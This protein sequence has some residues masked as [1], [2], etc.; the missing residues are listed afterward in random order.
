MVQDRI[1]YSTFVYSRNCRLFENLYNSQGFRFMKSGSRNPF[2]CVRKADCQILL[3]R[4]TVP[5][6]CCVQYLN[7]SLALDR[8]KLGILRFLYSAGPVNGTWYT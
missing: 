5:T 2:L 3:F 6:G 4:S 1:R 7:V 8:E